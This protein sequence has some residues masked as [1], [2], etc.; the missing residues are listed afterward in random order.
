MEFIVYLF[1]ACL[2]FV[3]VGDPLFVHALRSRAP[4]AFSA[5]GSP[6][7]G[8]LALVTPYFISSY[9]SFIIKRRFSAHLPRGSGLLIMANM[10]FSAHILVIALV[11]IMVL[12]LF[13]SWLASQFGGIAS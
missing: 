11:V 9:H 12:S 2:L 13:A 1:F 10:L 6:S 3:A 4:A 5:A 8:M 7:G